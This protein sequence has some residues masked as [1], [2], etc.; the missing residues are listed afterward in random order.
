M[1]NALKAHRTLCY[2]F[3]N[4]VPDFF[5]F[6]SSSFSFSSSL[7]LLNNGWTFII[8]SSSFVEDKGFAPFFLLLLDLL[9]LDEDFDDNEPEEDELYL[10]SFSS[11]LVQIP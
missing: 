5:L 3:A 11:S 4:P 2:V 10:E 1:V 9:F 8:A 7:F 6:S